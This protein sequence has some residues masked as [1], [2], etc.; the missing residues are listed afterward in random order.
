MIIT[1]ITEENLEAFAPVLPENVREDADLMLGAVEEK[2]PVGAAA[3]EAQDGNLLLSYVYVEEAFRKQG[4]LKEFLKIAQEIAEDTGYGMIAA[5]YRLDQETEDLHESLKSLG[6]SER[7]NVADV[8]S[9]RFGELAGNFSE[10]PEAE[11]TPVRPF[12]EITSA[13]F[14]MLER[15]LESL[16]NSGK[17]VI[18]PVLKQREWYDRE[19]SVYV[20]GPGNEI[21][22]CLLIKRYPGKVIRIEYLF[23]KGNNIRHFLAMLSASI[24]RGRKLLS[25]DTLVLAEIKDSRIRSVL[26]RMSGKRPASRGKLVV[27]YREGV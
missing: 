17:N 1:L 9:V 26:T 18:L 27:Q 14:S 22:G 16:K 2:S 11:K 7:E 8:Y 23:N 10:D 6:F 5:C 19:L 13:R 20:P 4:I 25:D 24:K 12:S 3:F 15:E 21:M